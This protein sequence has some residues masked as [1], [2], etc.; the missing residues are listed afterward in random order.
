MK[1]LLNQREIDAILGRA[2]EETFDRGGLQRRAI[3][4]C[5]FRND[6]QMSDEYARC[7]SG[8]HEAFARTMSNSLGAYLRAHFEMVL[9]S[10]ELIPGR[11]FL[12]SF[13][14]TGFTSFLA[15]EPGTSAVVL[16]VDT[17]L[18]VPIIDVLLGGTGQPTTMSRE[19]TEIDREIMDGVAQMIG[20]QLETTWQSIG[21]K[22]K[23]DR[24]RQA[25]QIQSV[26][27]ATEKLTILSFEAKVNDTLGAITISFPAT[28]AIAMLREISSGPGKKVRTEQRQSV[29]VRANVLS[30]RFETTVGLAGLRIPLRELMNLR[31]GCVLNLRLPVKSPAALLLGGREYFEAVP[32]RSG[33]QRA[34]QLVR[35]NGS[36][37][38]IYEQP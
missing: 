25:A 13:Q 24:Q 17:A 30:C 3:E 1:K 10:V 27:S 16:Q 4:P 34:A 7:M 14:E 29:G 22:L 21:I 32:V 15:V 35:P 31:P 9:A 20:R 38:T 6:V 8:L 37:A 5:N 2:R 19:L 36:S 12:G 18:V 23:P 26:Y 28:M 33:N 11:D